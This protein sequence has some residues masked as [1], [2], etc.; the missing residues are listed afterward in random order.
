VLAPSPAAAS[1]ALSIPLTQARRVRRWMVPTAVAAG[2]VAVAGAMMVTRVSTSDD[3]AGGQL[4]RSPTPAEAVQPVAVDAP[5]AAASQVGVE[6]APMIR[7]AELDRYLQAHRQYANGAM[8]V[9]PGGAVR[10]AAAT[11]PG[12]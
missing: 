11:A 7:S 9:A 6:M 3:A 2:F 5:A 10:N 1:P 4:A 12:R 8:Q